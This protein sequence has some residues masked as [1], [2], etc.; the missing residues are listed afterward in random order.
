MVRV[1][2]GAPTYSSD[3]SNEISILPILQL[4]YFQF[5]LFSLRR[6]MEQT[7]IGIS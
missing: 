7:Y 6:P 1:T 2:G 5:T 4:V 3:D